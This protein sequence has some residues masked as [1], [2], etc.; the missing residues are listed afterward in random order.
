MLGG[1]RS[2]PGRLRTGVKG[3]P[4]HR[5]LRLELVIV[6][7][8]AFV[9]AGGEPP[10]PRAMRPRTSIAIFLPL[11]VLAT[12]V[13]GLVYV[14]LQQDLRTGANDPQQQLAEDA[15]AQLNAG[16]TPGNLASGAKIDIAASL[17][18]F[19]VIYDGGGI[20]LAT[21]GELDGLPPMLP[22]GVLASARSS[23]LDSV[24]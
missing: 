13:S 8:A 5:T 4:T 21:T 15:A 11:A 6:S 18:S 7:N 23:G 17:A 9:T 1:R 14:G 19:V 2:G 12:C 22:S 10:S 20:V 16:V 24:T 3:W